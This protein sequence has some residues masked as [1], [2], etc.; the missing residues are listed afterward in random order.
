M[1]FMK[2][3]KRTKYASVEMF[4]SACILNLLFLRNELSNQFE[5]NE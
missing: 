4:Q 3:R 2:Q 5:K 1:A